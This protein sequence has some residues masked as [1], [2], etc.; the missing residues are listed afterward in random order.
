[1]KFEKLNG[2]NRKQVVR[3]PGTFVMEKNNDTHEY[4]LKQCLTFWLG[5]ERPNQQAMLFLVIKLAKKTF[6]ENNP[7]CQYAVLTGFN[8]NWVKIGEKK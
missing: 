5:S 7:R 8:Q 3:T 2:K 4:I 6:F 1:M